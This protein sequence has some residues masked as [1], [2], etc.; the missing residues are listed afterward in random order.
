MREIVMLKYLNM[1]RLT[2][3][4]LSFPTFHLCQTELLQCDN[5]EAIIFDDTLQARCSSFQQIFRFTR[6]KTIQNTD[7]I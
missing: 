4:S 2:C 1:R 3:G 7:S 6:S 5:I